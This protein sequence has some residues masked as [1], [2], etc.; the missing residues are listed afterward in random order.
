MTE[1]AT[2]LFLGK[3]TEYARYRV[4]YPESVISAALQ[5][6]GIVRDDVIADLGSGTGM[7]SRWF[8][9]RGNRVFGV[10]PDDGMRQVAEKSLRKFGAS[11]VSVNGTAERI[12]A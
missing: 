12:L 11:Y 2:S 4:D 8:L 10:E 9:E 3:A 6:V 7:L 1:R 5:S